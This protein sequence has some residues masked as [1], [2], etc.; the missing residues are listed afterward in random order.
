MTT[1]YR[2]NVELADRPRSGG[3]RKLGG[4]VFCIQVF[5]PWAA[6]WNPIKMNKKKKKYMADAWIS[7]LTYSVLFT[8]ILLPWHTRYRVEVVQVALV[9][10]LFMA[11]LN[12]VIQQLRKLNSDPAPPFKLKADGEDE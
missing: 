6:L 7:I 5:R 3:K 2:S 1:I 10:S 4:G 11:G 12:E 8:A 9:L